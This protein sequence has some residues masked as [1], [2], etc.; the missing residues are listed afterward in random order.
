M[1]YWILLND[2]RKESIKLSGPKKDLLAFLTS[3]Y[4][5]VDLK[6]ATA[7]VKKNY[8]IPPNFKGY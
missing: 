6:T 4:Y 5:N 8:C 2:Y 7:L 1:I 3:C